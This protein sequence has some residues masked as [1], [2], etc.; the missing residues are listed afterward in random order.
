MFKRT[1][2]LSETP[3]ITVRECRGGLTVRGENDRQMTLMVRD[4][5]GAV[6]LE[7]EGENVSFSAA[8]DCTLICPAGTVLTVERAL[9]NLRVE[10]VKGPIDTRVIHGNATLRTVG[11]VS[12]GETL[13]NLSAREVSGTFKAGDVKGNARVRGVKGRLTLAEV[14]GNLTTEEME[15]GLEA[16]LGG[17]T[18]RGNVQLGPPFSPG[19]AY[20]VSANGNMTVW[21]PADAS[22]RV[23]VRAEGKVHSRVP[24]LALEREGGEV[25]GGLGDGE[26]MLEADVRGNVSLRPARMG[27]PSEAD[28]GLEDLGAQIEWQVNEALATMA[29]RLEASLGRVDAEAVTRRVERVAEEAR[30]KAERAAEQARLRAERA[31][32]RWQRASGRSPRPRQV[33]TDEERLRVLRMVEDGK[34]TPEEAS[35]LLAVLEGE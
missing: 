4:G 17:G 34:I 18:V 16:G 14:G 23:A 6:D 1:I 27:E 19:T 13:G 30:R 9:G 29:T 32:R 2:E 10:G 5:D 12:L 26:A 24:G 8:A 25:R 35:D 20:R 7:Q 33:A 31:E 21:L 28:P 15:G 11:Q 3:H 22:I